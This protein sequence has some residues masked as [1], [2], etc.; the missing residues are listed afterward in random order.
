MDCYCEIEE[1]VMGSKKKVPSIR[2]PSSSR[3]SLSSF[4]SEDDDS[5]GYE[6]EGESLARRGIR[7]RKRNVGDVGQSNWMPLEG[8]FDPY[9]EGIRT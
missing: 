7:G 5:G 9:F 8:Y 1:E 4:A 3:A 2:L 6:G